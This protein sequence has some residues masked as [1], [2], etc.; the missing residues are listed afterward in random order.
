MQDARVEEQASLVPHVT[1]STAGCTAHLLFQLMPLI[2]LLMRTLLLLPAARR[3]SRGKRQH[4]WIA[5][6]EAEHVTDNPNA[7]TTTKPSVVQSHASRCKCPC[8]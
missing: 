4:G 1:C 3:C 7:R 2:S 8:S 5:W 6:L